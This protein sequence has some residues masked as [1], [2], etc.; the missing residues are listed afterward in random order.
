MGV[1]QVSYVTHGPIILI[2]YRDRTVFSFFFLSFFPFLSAKFLRDGWVDV[3]KIFRD[4]R[5]WK[6]LEDFFFIILKFYSRSSI[7]C[8]ET[9]KP[10]LSEISETVKTE[11]SKLCGMIDVGDMQN[12]FSILLLRRSGTLTLQTLIS[13]LY[14][15]RWQMH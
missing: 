8:F 2:S 12:L 15:E 7:F 4:G 1:F 14:R 11:T 10:C 3:P 5:E 13:R 6:Y 9:K